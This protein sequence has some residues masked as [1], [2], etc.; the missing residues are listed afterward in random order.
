MKKAK[1]NA[2]QCNACE[3]EEA[4]AREWCVKTV[5]LYMRERNHLFLASLCIIYRD[6]VYLSFRWKSLTVCT[7]GRSPQ[8]DCV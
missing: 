1:C 5:S 6:F 2:M 8:N 7:C 4:N 3:V